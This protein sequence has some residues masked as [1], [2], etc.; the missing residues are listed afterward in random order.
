[1]A[2]ILGNIKELEGART[3]KGFLSYGGRIF[4][5]QAGDA[6]RRHELAIQAGISSNK[7]NKNQE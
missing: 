7:F 5:L 4:M 2:V 3:I 1:M 6:R